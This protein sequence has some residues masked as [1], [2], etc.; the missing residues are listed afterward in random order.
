MT[1]AQVRTIQTLR[2]VAK[3]FLLF[4]QV[5]TTNVSHSELLEI[6]ALVEHGYI[7]V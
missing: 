6:Q 4:L 3:G 1:K 5:A 2:E 7:P